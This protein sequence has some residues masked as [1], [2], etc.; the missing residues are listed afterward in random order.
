MD[1]EQREKF[2]YALN[3]PV[4]G[5]AETRVAPKEIAAEN[6]SFLAMMSMQSTVE[7]R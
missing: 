7:G 4:P 2:D 1:E 3:Q 5:A 6:D